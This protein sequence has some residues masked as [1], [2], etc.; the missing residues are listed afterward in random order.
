MSRQELAEAVNAYLLEYTGREFSID[1]S[2]IGRLERGVHRWPCAHYRKALRAVLGAERD[3]DLGFYINRTSE[4][5]PEAQSGPRPENR[6]PRRDLMAVEASPNVPANGA[7]EAAFAVR[8]KD[9]RLRSGHSLRRLGRL[10]HYSHGHLGDLENGRKLPTKE[11]A[12]ALDRVLGADGGLS[13]LLA[14]PDTDHAAPDGRIG[15]NAGAG[16]P[17]GP[18]QTQTAAE[19]VAAVQVHVGAGA[20]VTVV[21]Y[22][23]NPGRVAVLAGSVRVLIDASGSDAA[24]QA[25]VWT[26]APLVAGDARVYSLTERRAR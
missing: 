26:G 19:P 21:C 25:P 5:L 14:D 3:A 16:G 9:L 22:D 17:H 12:A 20:E 10:V 11:V 4:E 18:A 13:G 15:S 7:V 8:L 6:A 24:G 2:H 1:A 23:G